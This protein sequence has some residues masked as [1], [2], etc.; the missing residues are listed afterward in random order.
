MTIPILHAT[1]ALALG[2]AQVPQPAPDH[3][4][5][6]DY[7]W[8]V[9]A[10]VAASTADGA[11]S[12]GRQELN[13]ILGRGRFGARQAGIKTG[14]TGGALLVQWLACRRHP[15]RRSWFTW[16]NVGTAG[17]M[18]AAAGRALKVR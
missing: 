6:R 2:C 14:I 1:M 16:V 11:A 15:G 9:A 7:N 10:L 12:W 5:R 4:G 17:A 3:Y 8:S 13:P 18:G